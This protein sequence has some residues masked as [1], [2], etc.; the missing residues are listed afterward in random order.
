ML[1]RLQRHRPKGRFGWFISGLFVLWKKKRRLL[2]KSA[3]FSQI[4]PNSRPVWVAE[5]R[6]TQQV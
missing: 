1:N 3:G 5:R 2:K 4:R 6:L